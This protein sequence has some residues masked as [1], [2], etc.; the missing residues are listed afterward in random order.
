M[1]SLNWLKK[2]EGRMNLVFRLPANSK[3]DYQVKG[4][5][6][7]KLCN[8]CDTIFESLGSVI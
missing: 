8:D 4:I 5:T 3:L 6:L 2:D 7:T 1:S